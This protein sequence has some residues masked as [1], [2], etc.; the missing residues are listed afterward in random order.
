M[1][2]DKVH[3]GRAQYIIYH[4]F[5]GM[6]VSAK[7]INHKQS[8]TDTH[9][10]NFA[11]LQS[12]VSHGKSWL[13]PAGSAQPAA[14]RMVRC[15][16]PA[17]DLLVLGNWWNVYRICRKLRTHIIW[18]IWTTQVSGS[19]QSFPWDDTAFMEKGSLLG[20]EAK[21]LKTKPPGPSIYSVRVDCCTFG[22]FELSQPKL[23]VQ[24]SFVVHSCWNLSSSCSP[25]WVS[26]A[27]RSPELPIW[28]IQPLFVG[29][30]ANFG[31]TTWLWLPNLPLTLMIFDEQIFMFYQLGLNKKHIL[32]IV[33]S[34]NPYIQ[35]SLILISARSAHYV[36][37]LA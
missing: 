6:P 10:H 11:L 24:A 18:I 35:E 17:R 28:S 2:T 20:E 7:T 9:T 15:S 16:N 19:C 4:H 13:G 26:N 22:P 30:S 1:R 3:S 33:E 29:P 32:D 25:T 27:C 37:S 14:D 23:T 21:N 5:L 34:I 12:W 31:L 8:N 36:I